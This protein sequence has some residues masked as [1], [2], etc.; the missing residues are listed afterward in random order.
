ML[1]R[2]LR[3]ALAA[4]VL[5]AAG[6]GGAGASAGTPPG[7]PLERAVLSG[8][9]FWGMQ[10]VFSSLVGVVRTEAGYAGGAA[11]TAHY[12]LVSTGTTGHAESVSIWYDPRR[13]SYRQL[14]A[15]Y[16]EVAHDPTE[17]DRQGPDVGSQYRSAIWYLDGRQR[18]QASAA[19]A[20][21][22]TE[23]RFGAPIVTAVVPFRGFFAAESYHQN[24]AELHPSDPYIA[25]NDLPK[26]AALE[27]QFPALV[28]DRGRIARLLAAAP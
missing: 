18:A 22:R 25:F 24:F 4:T 13:I 20:A 23:R 12:D 2:T 11:A 8:G 9:C 19:I 21:L 16:F 17:L 5:F 6:V 7:P 10:L 14:L 27:R 26:L 1:F 15:V 3:V 28:A